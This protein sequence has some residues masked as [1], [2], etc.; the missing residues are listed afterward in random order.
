[1]VKSYTANEAVHSD[2][3]EFVQF[4]LRDDY[5]RVTD[6][7]ADLYEQ[8]DQGHM[9]YDASMSPST[10]DAMRK[11]A[12]FVQSLPCPQCG[13]VFS[14]ELSL[15]GHFEAAHSQSSGGSES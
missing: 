11:A 7:L 10:Q 3:G 5:N 14:T 12:E 13:R 9:A 6:A 8:V 1:M 2:H 4:V 15:A